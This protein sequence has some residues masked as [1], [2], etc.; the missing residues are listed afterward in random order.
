[1]SQSGDGERLDGAIAKAVGT[2]N[3][4]AAFVN[5]VMRADFVHL[6]HRA[7]AQTNRRSHAGD[8]GNPRAL[9]GH[10]T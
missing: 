8:I 3:I 5:L 1:V 4:D 6:D 10:H 2:E 9:N 7:G